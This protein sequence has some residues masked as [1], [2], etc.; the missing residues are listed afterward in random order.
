MNGRTCLL[1]VDEVREIDPAETSRRFELLAQDRG[2]A[3]PGE[4]GVDPT[5]QRDDEH[6][7][8]QIR[9]SIDLQ[10]T[11]TLRACALGRERPAQ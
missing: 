1:E 3:R 11:N 9:P 6:R 2:R 7:I 8:A 5:R 4:A 10:H